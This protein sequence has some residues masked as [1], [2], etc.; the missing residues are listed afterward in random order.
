MPVLH[1]T[2]GKT[3][4][5][6]VEKAEKVLANKQ[7]SNVDQSTLVDIGTKDFVELRQIKRVEF[8]IETNVESEEWKK[9]W[10]ERRLE[11]ER[12]D[13]EREEWKKDDPETKAKRMLRTGC[14]LL[15]RARFN[16][17]EYGEEL[18]T[19]LMIVLLEYFEENPDQWWAGREVYQH[20]IP[21]NVPPL[22]SRVQG[23]AAFGEAMQKR[24]EN[25]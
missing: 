22:V 20:L 18:L 19:K 2:G 14:Y 24:F 12:M 5:V 6:S 10:E 15:W 3:A 11:A 16:K 1:L 4:N 9:R 8:Q 25:N 17:G 13:K 21:S 23:F 7:D